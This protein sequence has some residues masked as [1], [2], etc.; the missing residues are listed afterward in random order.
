MTMTEVTRQGLAF[1]DEYP[2]GSGYRCPACGK[3][4]LKI[5]SCGL[6]WD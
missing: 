4:T 1:I 5:A 6:R 3:H 2:Q